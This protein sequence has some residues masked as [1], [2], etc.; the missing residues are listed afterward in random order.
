MQ[1]PYMMAMPGDEVGVHRG[2]AS[3]EKQLNVCA[4]LIPGT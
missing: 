3:V 4:L 1:M 2:G